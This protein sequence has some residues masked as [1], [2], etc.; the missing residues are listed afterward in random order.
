M[1][2]HKPTT[3]LLLGFALL[4]TLLN[5]CAP[6]PTVETPQE[7]DLPRIQSILVL[8]AEIATETTSRSP[9]EKAQLA[10]GQRVLDA[11]LAEHFASNAKATF[12]TEEQRDAYN[13]EFARCR[14]T[15]AVTICKTF[16]AEAVLV[17]SIHRF[18]E[19]Q[20]TEYAVDNPASVSFDYKLIMGGS[21]QV[22]CTGAFDE[23]QQPLLN[24]MFQFADKT[25]KRGVR[26]LTA[27]TLLREGAIE[28]LGKCLYLKQ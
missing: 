3:I 21:G 23:T 8:P 9:Q 15:S 20:G 10:Q 19:R 25:S 27:E 26:W 2:L 5:G 22:L 6:A 16:K 1:T 13:K 7:A 4:A 12:L 28:K 11:I 24:D 18:R 17:C 14:T